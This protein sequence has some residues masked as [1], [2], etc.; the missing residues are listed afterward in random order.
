MSYNSLYLLFYTS[1]GEGT[2]NRQSS[3]AVKSQK[4]ALVTRMLGCNLL[5]GPLSRVGTKMRFWT[6]FW[7]AFWFPFLVIGIKWAKWFAFLVA[8]LVPFSRLMQ[9]GPPPFGPFLAIDANG[10]PVVPY[11]SF[12]CDCFVKWGTNYALADINIRLDGVDNDVSLGNQHRLPS[13][14][15]GKSEEQIGQTGILK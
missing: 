12:F 7:F 1:L 15:K 9:M 10:S 4:Q 2:L 14:G 5:F 6:S 8:H 3:A 11:W 13:F